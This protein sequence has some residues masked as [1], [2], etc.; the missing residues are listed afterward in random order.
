MTI[1]EIEKYLIECNEYANICR[2]IYIA[3]SSNPE[4]NKVKD[5]ILSN[6][7]VI[8]H[9]NCKKINTFTLFTCFL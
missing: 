9:H 7:T 8:I 2:Q 6:Y 1:S 3:L 4:L 5:Y